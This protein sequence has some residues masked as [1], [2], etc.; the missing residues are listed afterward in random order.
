MTRINLVEPR[1]L[2]DQHLLAEYRELPRVFWLV[3]KKIQENKEVIHWNKFTMWTWHVIFFYNKLLFLEKRFKSLVLECEK[4]GFNIK[5]SNYD[6]SDIPDE[7]KKDYI[8]NT[9]DIKISKERLNTK[10]IEK[11]WFYRMYWKIID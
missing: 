8:P 2:T 7:F 3:R 10:I 5:Y 4:R 6:I 11:K 9:T 1:K